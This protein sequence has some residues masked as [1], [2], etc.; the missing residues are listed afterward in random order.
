MDLFKGSTSISYSS[1]VEISSCEV[2][3]FNL[4]VEFKI[5]KVEAF[6]T[7]IRKHI[8]VYSSKIGSQ[9]YIRKRETRSG[10]F[11]RS[12]KG[13]IAILPGEQVS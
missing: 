7:I 12:R 13:T 2:E 8:W 10:H 6:F 9:V 3:V 4:K 5:C 1:K 11:S